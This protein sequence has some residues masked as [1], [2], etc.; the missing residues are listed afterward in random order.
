VVRRIAADADI[1]HSHYPHRKNSRLSEP[2]QQFTDRDNDPGS[3][4]RRAPSLFPIG[5]TLGFV[6]LPG[7]YWPA[8]FAI[9]FGYCIL[10]HLVKIWFVRRWGL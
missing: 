5:S 8:V 10:A 9:I 3:W 1:G 2:C 7:L 4:C 6:P